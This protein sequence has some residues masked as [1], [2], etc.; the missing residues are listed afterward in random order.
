MKQQDMIR[1]L[2]LRNKIL[3]EC[4]SEDDL[5][6]AKKLEEE[7]NLFSIEDLLKNQQNLEERIKNLID[8]LTE[9]DTLLGAA[10]LDNSI[11]GKQWYLEQIANFLD[12]E[13]PE[14]IPG[15]K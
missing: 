14:H 12:V 1:L 4:Y 3:N 15:K 10:V 6:E 11:S 13:L 8:S 5:K 2:E 7:F 9:I